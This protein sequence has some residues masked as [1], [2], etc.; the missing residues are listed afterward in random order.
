MEI[1]FW[2]LAASYWLH[3][4]ATVAWLGGLAAFSIFTLPLVNSFIDLGEKVRALERTQKKLDPLGWLGLAVL[5]GTGLVQMSANPNY[6]GFLSIVNQWALAIL[7][8]HI[9]FLGMVG[10]SAYITWSVLP[11]LRRLVLRST[12]GVS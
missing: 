7:L 1:P 5:T 10:L 9:V 6:E 4:A 2:A 12:K 11:E 8:K 3:M